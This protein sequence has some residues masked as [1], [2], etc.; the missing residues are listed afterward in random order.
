M[1]TR[2]LENIDTRRL[3]QE[4]K[5]AREKRNLK[6]EDAARIIDVA[7]TTM[8]AI[9]KGVRRVK[10]E[11]L[12]ELA[13]AYGRQVSDFMR[14]RPEIQPFRVQY[15]GPYKPKAED[16]ERIQQYEDLFESLCRDYVELEDIVEA[17]LPREYPPEYDV[18]GLPVEQAA[19]EIATKERNRLGLG[20]CP[21]GDLRAILEE[22]V[23]IRIFY[24]EMQPSTFSE[25]YYYDDSLG[26]CMAINRLHPPERRL[27]SE[28]HGF[29][30]FL[31][32][33]YQAVVHVENVYQRVP[34]SE[35]LA[36]FFALYFLMPTTEVRE[37]YHKII[38]SKDYPTPADLCILADYFGVAVAAMTRRLEDMRMLPTGTW[39]KLKDRGFRV[40]EAQQKLGLRAKG[41]P[42]DMMPLR[43]QYLALEGLEAGRISEGQFARFLRLDRLEARAVAESLREH[44]GGITDESIVDIDIRQSLKENAA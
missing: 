20:S 33:R 19:E 27:W 18:K 12:I 16:K 22:K 26:A 32:H 36:D 6:Q 42:P 9:E 14:P 10:A 7:R 34:E 37:R 40:R 35:Q 1:E 38:R 30:H 23:G 44:A 24:I 3:G 5:L 13:R 29:L 21:I 15:R 8:V 31:A 41:S 17:P 25:M 2:T 28:G 39:K 43:Y 11:E 4:L